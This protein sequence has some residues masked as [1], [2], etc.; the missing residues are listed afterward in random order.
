[1][2]DD[3]NTLLKNGSE[4][5]KKALLHIRSKLDEFGDEISWEDKQ[6]VALSLFNNLNT[7]TV[8]ETSKASQIFNYKEKITDLVK[9]FGKD[10]L[11]RKDYLKACIKHPELFRRSAETL[12][13]N[14]EGVLEYFKK[15]N[16]DRKAYLRAC[17]K[18]PTL[19]H[20][21]IKSISD[22][23]E[24]V[25]ANFKNDGLDRKE[26][27]KACVKQPPLFCQS[28]ETLSRHI[29][30][31][32]TMADMGLL[33]KKSDS[34]LPYSDVLSLALHNPATLCFADENYILRIDHGVR[35][36]AEGNNFQLMNL[37]KA[38]LLDEYK[39]NNGEEFSLGLVLPQIK[40]EL[41][42]RNLWPEQKPA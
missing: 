4:F 24:T 27:L 18:Q 2:T 26:Y 21:S 28:S 9:V 13:N 40:Q 37:H 10:G 15:D 35:T 14:V 31:L 3:D 33:P 11:D 38:K 22:N 17:L 42:F 34:K 8:K 7:L 16:L 6:K 1:M 39:N 23:V 29:E 41:Q 19:F 32:K 5:E 30:Y 20:R 36:S 25:L 12:S